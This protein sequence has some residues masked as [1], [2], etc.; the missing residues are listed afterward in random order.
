MKWIIKILQYLRKAQPMPE[1]YDSIDAPVFVWQK[2]HET[3]DFTYLLKD[4]KEVPPH[5]L[6]RLVTAWEKI[7]DE[8]LAEF[9]F[10]DLFLDIKKKEVALALLKLELII[11]GD[12]SLE[13]FIEIEEEELKEMQKELKG[14]DFMES[15]IAIET[16]MKFQINPH[17]TTIRKFYSYLKLLK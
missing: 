3:R 14:V 2:V 4:R 1:H 13:T 8:F 15:T 17:N 11:T 12:R 6:I 5:I 10:N 9:G 16:R 7:Y